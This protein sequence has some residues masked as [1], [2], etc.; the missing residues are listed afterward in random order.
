MTTA[1]NRKTS[2]NKLASNY[3]TH[4]LRTNGYCAGFCLTLDVWSGFQRNKMFSRAQLV[5]GVQDR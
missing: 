4:D 5:R 2:N 1:F 3:T